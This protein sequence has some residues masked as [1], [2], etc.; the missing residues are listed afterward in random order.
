MQ[1]VN[2]HTPLFKL[3]DM[4]VEIA[5]MLDS[6]CTYVAIMRGSNFEDTLK[7][8]ERSPWLHPKDSLRHTII[9]CTTY[10]Y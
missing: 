1:S 7:S 9:P 5:D 6:L 8:T 4:F 3:G 10:L 2:S